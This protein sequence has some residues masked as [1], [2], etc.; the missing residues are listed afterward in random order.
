M[1]FFRLA[2]FALLAAVLATAAWAA[3]PTYVQTA[4]T[5]GVAWVQT[6]SDRA[7]LV[8]KD[9][10]GAILGT[11]LE[12]ITGPGGDY[13]ILRNA[14]ACPPFL[15]RSANG[16]TLLVLDGNGNPLNP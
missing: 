1:R 7:S 3:F 15:P 16:V 10:S 5:P 4:D 13:C 9:E 14:S 12:C 11:Y 8:C 2:L 6:A